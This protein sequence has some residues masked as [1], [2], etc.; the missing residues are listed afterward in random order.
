[1]NIKQMIATAVLG[2]AVLAVLPLATQ[3]SPALAESVEDFVG[4]EPPLFDTPE[5][6]VEAFKTKM[7][8]GDIAELAALLGLD[9]EK[10]KGVEGIADRIAELRAATAK[11]VSVKGEGDER[12]LIIGQEVWPFPFPLVKSEKD[13]KWAFD[14]VA[15]VEEIVNRR[16][17]ENEL[18][19]IETARL[20]VEAQRAYAEEDRDG[21]GVLEYA[22]AL[23]SSE[24]RTDGLYW[25]VEQGDGESPMGPNI[26]Q[27][28]LD[29]AAAGDGYFGYRF[30]I[31]KRQGKN[32]AGGDYDYVINGNMIAG[33]ALLAW[34]VDYA[35][36]GVSTFVISHAGIVYE[37]D[38]GPDTG[39]IVK[40]IKSFNPDR[41]WD[42]VP[43]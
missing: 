31:L 37:K 10:L 23:I 20:Y 15:G 21:D 18:Q 28:A 2:T 6:A 32:I 38:L 3:P 35:R 12:I 16:I 30:R 17:G 9:V 5:A 13:G 39:E 8:K 33:F 29:K 26:N 27:A 22:Q 36:T 40:K 1:M 34:P 11:L 41:S 4:A 19:A 7:A 14:T 25:P 24:G 42:V 43:E